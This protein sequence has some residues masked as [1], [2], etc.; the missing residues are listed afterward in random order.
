[1]AEHSVDEVKALREEIAKLQ[2]K[3]SDLE[4]LLSDICGQFDVLLSEKQRDLAD[5]STAWVDE[6]NK[7]LEQCANEEVALLKEFSS[8]LEQVNESLVDLKRILLRKN[9]ELGLEELA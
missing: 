6:G 2:K 5:G 4:A 8:A 9:R 1:M 7:R 3:K